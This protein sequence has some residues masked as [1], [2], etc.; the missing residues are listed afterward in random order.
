MNLKY[1]VLVGLVTDALFAKV[2]INTAVKGIDKKF[3]EKYKS[4]LTAS[5]C[6]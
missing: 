3:I 5:K 6:K 2:D 1:F 4:E